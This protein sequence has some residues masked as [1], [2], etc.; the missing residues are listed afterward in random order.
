MEYICQQFLK[1]D[2]DGD[3]SSH[4]QDGCIV[5]TLGGETAES[6]GGVKILSNFDEHK[7]STELVMNQIRFKTGAQVTISGNTI[8]YT[9]N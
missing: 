6:S 5:I 9:K 7:F 1:C 8:C 2:F 4:P 3:W